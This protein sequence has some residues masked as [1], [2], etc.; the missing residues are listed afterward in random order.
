[1]SIPTRLASLAGL[2]ALSAC[3][4]PFQAATPT[5]QRPTVS[6]DT[7]LTAPGTIEIESGFAMEAGESFDLPNTLKLGLAETSEVFVGFS[8]QRSTSVPG[9]NPRGAGDVLVGTRARLFEDGDFATA[10]QFATR[11]PGGNG[12]ESSI[13]G[14]TDFFL[15]G[16]VGNRM[17]ELDVTGFYQLGLLGDGDDD[18]IFAEHTAALAL[19]AAASDTVGVFGE[20]AAIF[21]PDLDTNVVLVTGGASWNWVPN[22]TWDGALLVGLTEDSPDYQL[23]VGLT[24]NL[25]GIPTA[26]RT[27]EATP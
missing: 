25:G 21:R 18:S 9:P 10:L 23:L 15:A 5:P 20:I 26:A 2:L 14:D 4:S 11:L 8:P 24:W 12:G 7:N 1:M 19:S 16:I 22:L 17:G 3:S 6:S 13:S 27:P